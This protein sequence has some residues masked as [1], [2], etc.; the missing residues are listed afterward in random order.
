ATARRGVLAVA[1]L[2]A[3]SPANALARSA[4]ALS[5]ASQPWA[6]RGKIGSSPAPAVPA[7]GVVGAA[8]LAAGAC[9]GAAGVR[10]A[11]V[12]WHATRSTAPSILQNMGR[13]VVDAPV[14]GKRRGHAPDSGRGFELG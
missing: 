8:G 2:S 10:S 12:A 11:V 13:T 14:P 4:V 3:Y 9:A 5:T 6:R 7:A 1:R